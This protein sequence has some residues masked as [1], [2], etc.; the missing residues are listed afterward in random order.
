MSR[1]VPCVEKKLRALVRDK[2]AEINLLKQELAKAKSKP[3]EV[4]NKV[5]EDAHPRKH[6]HTSRR[7]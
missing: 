6:P 3:S 1:C 5:N 4:T 7:I 2:Q